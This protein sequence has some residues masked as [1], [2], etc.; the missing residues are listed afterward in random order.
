MDDNANPKDEIEEIELESQENS[1]ED[2][3]GLDE[4]ELKKVE[5]L[6]KSK[7]KRKKSIV[8]TQNKKNKPEANKSFIDICKNNILIPITLILA[9]AL[10]VF[11]I[12]YF[13][14]KKE[15]INSLGFTYEEL[16]TNYHKTTAYNTL[17]SGDFKT[18][19]PELQ[20]FENTTEN[21]NK[22]LEYFGAS[23]DK[24]FT[25][26]GVAIQGSNRKSDKQITGLRVMFE[27]PETSEEQ[28]ANKT[29]VFFFY[30]MIMNSVYPDLTAS[31]I[32]AMLA[33]TSKTQTFEVYGNIAYRFSIQKDGNVSFYALDFAPA[34]DYENLK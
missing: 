10:I 8:N 11:G 15:P 34:A 13:W 20:Y 2:E 25:S 28:E 4:E 1:N 18:E 27:V 7:S 30:E 9:V 12:I 23:F 29:V 24:T 14:P 33:S 17:F 26:Y 21:N 32:D 16:I 19:L 5:E 6:I 22:E 3:Y 31:D